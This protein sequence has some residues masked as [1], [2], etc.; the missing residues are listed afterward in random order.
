MK[1]LILF[2]IIIISTT[3]CK[4]QKKEFTLIGKWKAIES[5]GSDGAK[6][7]RTDI[8]DGN[9]LVFEKGNIISD[10]LK[11]KG[12]YEISENRLHII[13]PNEE[14]YYIYHQDESDS[15]KMYL[16]PVSADYTILCD[17]GCST[18]YEKIE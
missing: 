17:E 4:F 1:K 10:N 18:T 8:E 2:L 12:K 13:F 6:M 3:S 5:S 15:E 7:Y 11:N 16:Q 9:E 14:I